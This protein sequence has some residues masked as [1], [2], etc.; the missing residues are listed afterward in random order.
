VRHR[1]G[2]R[3]AALAHYEQ[4]VAL[5]RETGD[6]YNEADTLV[7]IGDTHHEAGD[8]PAACDAWRRADAILT[9]LRHPDAQRACE[10]L[11]DSNRE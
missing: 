4:A 6:R 11:A 5:F 3:A 1:Q 7:R 8:V 2:D 9:E 10:R